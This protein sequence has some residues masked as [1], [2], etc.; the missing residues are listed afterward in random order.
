MSN[1]SNPAPS[2][3][4]TSGDSRD[5]VPLVRTLGLGAA[6]ALVVGN[7]IGAGIFLKPGEAAGHAGTVAVSLLAWLA[8]GLLCLLGAL[9]IAELALR[10]PRA[11]GLYL[12]LREAFGYRVAFLYGW[13]EF[14][15]GI[16]ASIGALADGSVMMIAHLTGQT[17][18]LWTKAIG[19]MALITLF[20]ALNIFS[21]MWSGRA[22]LTTTIVKCAFLAGLALLPV[23]VGLMGHPAADLANLRDVAA[24]NEPL[25]PWPVRFAGALLAV[26]WAYIGWHAVAP[27]AEEVLNPRKN[28]PR[29]LI[30]GGLLLTGL[31][32]CVVVA[33]HATMPIDAIRAAG[34]NL[35]QEMTNHVLRPW[36]DVAAI[37]TPRIISLAALVS[38]AGSLNACLMGGPRVGFAMARDGLFPKPIAQVHARF[39]T[40]A[41]AICLQSLIS[42]FLV[43]LSA[44][45]VSGATPFPQTSVFEFLSNYVTFIA[46]LFLTLAVACIFP[47]RR[48]LG[49][50]E[51]YRIPAYPWIPLVFVG[52]SCFFLVSLAWGQPREALIGVALALSGLPVHTWFTRRRPPSVPQAAASGV[53]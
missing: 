40:P 34:I 22:Q 52:A 3:S 14:V 49:P 2:D 42:I 41:A 16:P 28:I 32:V 29:A 30:G 15:I 51:G 45:L 27:V 43:V 11:G 5:A 12:Y 48:R 23:I 8:G 25:A 1:L 17:F 35:P 18:D 21:V 7:V 47:I 10:M 9:T 6:M 13:S 19:A 26:L 44:F 36:S 53:E 33:Y 39:Q 31:Y 20:A 24:S 38:M 50:P 37:W 46:S 4:V